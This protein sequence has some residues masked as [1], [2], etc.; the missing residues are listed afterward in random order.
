MHVNVRSLWRPDALW[1]A[2]YQK[3]PLVHLVYELRGPAYGPAA[4][5][6]KKSELVADLSQ[7]FA[8]AAEGRLEDH[9]RLAE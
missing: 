4:E 3:I 7:L 6:K 5:R 9:P 8:D 2:G 1:L